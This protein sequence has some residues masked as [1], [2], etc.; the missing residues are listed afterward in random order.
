VF[1]GPGRSGT[2]SIYHAFKASSTY[3]VMAEKE[4]GPLT[5]GGAGALREL[6]GKAV[7]TV[8]ADT[9]P[10][11]LFFSST[12]SRTVAKLDCPFLGYVLVLRSVVD[13]MTSLYLHHRKIGSF[14]HSF[15]EFVV[16]CKELYDS[17]ASW[18][19]D[20][21]EL[22]YIGLAEHHPEHLRALRGSPV[23]ALRFESLFH[24]LNALLTRRGLPAVEAKHRNQGY[25]PRWGAVHRVALWGYRVT[26]LRHYSG[27]DRAKQ[28]Y[29][30][31]NARRTG[32]PVRGHTREIL[33]EVERK[34]REALH[35]SGL[36]D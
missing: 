25:L 20:P 5:F 3:A 27:L 11:N 9:T 30:R 34:W 18:P 10:S 21:R 36:G 33:R 4:S 22:T 23:E 16:R 8:L 19:D 24:D 6:E 12:L 1:L 29:A 17:P 15:E 31:L 7:Q 13:R 26:G 28:M 32:V 2:T 35:R 14:E